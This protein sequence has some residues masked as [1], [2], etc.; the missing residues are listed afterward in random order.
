MPPH[1]KIIQTESLHTSKSIKKVH[2]QAPPT[3]PAYG[4][5]PSRSRCLRWL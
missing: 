5:Q 1:G 3:S 2:R 4:C